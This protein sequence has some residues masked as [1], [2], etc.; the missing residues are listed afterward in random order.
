M[1]LYVI[2]FSYGFDSVYG[3]GYATPKLAKE[4]E[5]KVGEEIIHFSFCLEEYVD[6]GINRFLKLC[7]AAMC[8]IDEC[9]RKNIAKEDIVIYQAKFDDENVKRDLKKIIDKCYDMDLGKWKVWE[10][11]E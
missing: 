2:V 8:I 4:D 11:Y 9:K 6:V 10:D 3:R 1:K 5:C 7:I